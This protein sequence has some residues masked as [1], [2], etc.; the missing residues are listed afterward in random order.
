MTEES[1]FD[2]WKGQEMSLLSICL[3]RL[4][5]P[6]NLPSQWALGALYPRIKLQ[7][8]E[9]NH[10]PPSS[11]TIKNCGAVTPPHHRS[12][13]HN[14]QCTDTNL[15]LLTQT[16]FKVIFI[17]DLYTRK[18]MYVCTYTRMYVPMYRSNTEH[19]VYIK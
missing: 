11:D 2:S 3:D 16:G 7:G 15:L 1:K 18:C 13:W 17:Q 8:R 14:A 19:Q 9:A 10:S 5:G 4:C 6:I 12:S